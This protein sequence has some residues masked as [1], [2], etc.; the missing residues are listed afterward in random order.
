MQGLFNSVYMPA[1]VDPGRPSPHSPE[2]TASEVSMIG[3]TPKCTV[4]RVS[5]QISLIGCSEMRWCKV[6]F[7]KTDS[8]SLVEMPL[9]MGRTDRINCSV[10][11][12]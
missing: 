5:M 9:N 7:V 11:W 6:L 4:L 2:E 1:G 10:W 12:C 3:G 8:A